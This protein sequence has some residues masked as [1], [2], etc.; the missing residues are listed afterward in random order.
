M[1][2]CTVPVWTTIL[3]YFI[4]GET[5]SRNQSISML[6]IVIGSAMVCYGDVWVTFIGLCF[7]FISVLASTLKG[8]FTKIILSGEKNNKLSPLQTLFLNSGFGI[9]EILPI[10]FLFDS[11]FY[12]HYIFVTPPSILILLLFHGLVAFLVN[13]SNFNAI[14]QSSPLVMNIVANIRQ[15][16]MI[17]FSIFVFHQPL[18]LLGCIGCVITISCSIWYFAEKSKDEGKSNVLEDVNEEN[19]K[20]A[21][22]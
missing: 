2:R 8:I 10:S 5:I 6:L 13:I 1:I 11:K 21:L 15:V 22:V 18:T 20:Q 19:E 9:I 7:L 12:T 14:K 4:T 16:C 3:Q 17:F